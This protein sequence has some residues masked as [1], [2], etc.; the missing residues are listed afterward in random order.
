MNKKELPKIENIKLGIIGLGYVGLPLA[1]A[2]AKAFKKENNYSN[3]IGFDKSQNRIY[4]LCNGYDATGEILKTEIDGLKNIIFTTEE[5]DL[6]EV[7][8]FII[9]VPTPVDK[10]NKPDL[11]TLK[12]ATQTVAEIIKNSEKC[13][14]RK[15]VVFESTVYPGA[16]EEVCQPII[17]NISSLKL[18]KDFSIGYSPE[19]VNPG[20][21]KH[22]LENIVK[23]VSASDKESL[24]LLNNLYSKVAKKGIH[25]AKSIKIAESAK[26]VENIQRDL[27]I[28][29]VNE[30]SMIFNKLDI[31][32]VEVLKA[33][34]TKW[35]FLNYQPGLVGGHCIGVDPYYLTY[36]SEV[37]GY[38][39]EIILAGRRINDNMATWIATTAM[40]KFMFQNNGFPDK[41]KA[42][43]FGITYKSNCPDVRNTKVMD[44]YRS[45]LE[46]GCSVD[47]CDPIP[48]KELV[49]NK[50]KLDITEESD[51][52]NTYNLIFIAVAHD[53]F[54]NKAP[55]YWRSIANKRYLI[56]DIKNIIPEDKDVM[57]I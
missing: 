15:V 56:I 9:S 52:A 46:F 43:I 45:L 33:A 35:N 11:K 20:D 26:V 21:Q 47:V 53:V 41:I 37:H 57:K 8:I 32:T 44:I 29:L 22:K 54:K 49:K 30:L 51:L 31:D 34:A 55:C 36:K 28:A 2:F 25:Q 17:E 6:L 1:I 4:E 50:Y 38:H 18:N 3:I 27:N 23:I 48:D 39:P 14:I 5:K 12:K 24:E 40:K 7:D 10:S 19:R 16:T 13:N 42:V